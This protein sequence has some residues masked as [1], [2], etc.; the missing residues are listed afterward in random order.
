M[1][2]Q[3]TDL[4]AALDALEVAAERAIGSAGGKGA[5]KSLHSLPER[6]KHRAPGAVLPAGARN[7]GAD[8]RAVLPFQLGVDIAERPVQSTRG[9]LAERRL[10]GTHVADEDEV[11]I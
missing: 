8:E 5:R 3:A 7:L 4:V 10:A 1:S 11:P 6:R 9:L 2:G